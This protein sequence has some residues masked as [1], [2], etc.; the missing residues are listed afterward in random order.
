MPQLRKLARLKIPEER[1][2]REYPPR[3]FSREALPLHELR[4]PPLPI[5]SLKRSWRRRFALL[6]QIVFVP[7]IKILCAAAGDSA[8]SRI[9]RTRRIRHVACG[10]FHDQPA[11]ILVFICGCCRTGNLWA[12]GG[13]SKIRLPTPYYLVH[14]D[15]DRF[16]ASLDEYKKGKTAA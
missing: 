2:L 10:G 4:L 14:K 9:S 6:P 16:L 15:V 13:P 7:P 3:C 12:G 8:L 11:C 5:P 1:Y